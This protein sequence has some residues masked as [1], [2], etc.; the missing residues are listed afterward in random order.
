VRSTLLHRHPELE[1]TISR[2]IE[3]ARVEEISKAKVNEWYDE[4]EKTISKYQ[5][6]VENMYNMDETGFSIGCIKAAKAVVNKNLETTRQARPGRQGWLSEIECVR[7]DRNTDI[8]K[9]V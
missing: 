2:T 8:K 7:A 6:T 4:F 5:T 3:A 9:S 1:I